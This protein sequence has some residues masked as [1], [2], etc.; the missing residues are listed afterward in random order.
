VLHID[1]AGH[2]V[3]GKYMRVTGTLLKTVD[4]HEAG[5]I[6]CQA[7]A[8]QPRP[9]VE[10]WRQRDIPDIAQAVAASVVGVR[11]NQHCL[12]RWH[13]GT[14]MAEGMAEIGGQIP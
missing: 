10:S 13:S 4:G 14:F 7:A 9:M 12:Q 11:A 1:A 5:V 2:I 6:Q 3:S 8:R